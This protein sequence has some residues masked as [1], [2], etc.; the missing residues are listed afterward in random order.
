MRAP[1]KDLR[2]RLERLL[3]GS[4]PDLQLEYLLLDSHQE[5]AEL[6]AHGDLVVLHELVG[7]E[8]VEQA[9]LADCAVANDNE[10]EQVVLLL[11]RLVLNDL[12]RHHHQVLFQLVSVLQ[13]QL[14]N[15][16][17]G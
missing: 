14:A 3:P 15:V 2:D 13:G 5:S 11:H 9:R 17:V 1:V 10:F 8:S 16:F 6:H 7:G 12:V 4:V